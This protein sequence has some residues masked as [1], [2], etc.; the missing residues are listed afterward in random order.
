MYSAPH[1]LLFRSDQKKMIFHPIG[2]A[3]RRKKT[4]MIPSSILLNTTTMRQNSFVT[5][6]YTKY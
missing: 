2:C 1:M 5:I 6:I 4:I 3:Q